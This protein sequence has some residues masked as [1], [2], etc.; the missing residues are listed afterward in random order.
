MPPHSNTGVVVAIINTNDDLVNVLRE[1][2]IEHGFNVV[3]G[4]IRDIKAGRLDFAEFLRAHNPTAIIYDI[5][6][7]YEDNWTFFQT[8]KQLPDAKHRDFVV[9]T[10]NRRVMQQRVG[11]ADVIEIQG[12]R[13]DDLDPVVDAVVKLR[14]K[15]RR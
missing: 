4:H 6:V 7:P 9:T 3:T 11:Q 14:S 2:L 8:L 1:A 12:G 13:A 5:A 15:G 10:V